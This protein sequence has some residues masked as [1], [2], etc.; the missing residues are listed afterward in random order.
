MGGIWKFLHRERANDYFI[1]R[2]CQ[3]PTR[4]KNS[5]WFTVFF[6]INTVYHFGVFFLMQSS[7]FTK[8][9][10]FG[11]ISREK[12]TTFFPVSP[13]NLF[14]CMQNYFLNL[15]QGIDLY[16]IFLIRNAAYFKTM[17]DINS[18]FCVKGV[19]ISRLDLLCFLRNKPS[20]VHR[21]GSTVHRFKRFSYSPKMFI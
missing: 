9:L 15:K 12:K 8:S 21:F 16:W 1:Y 17:K 6:S 2:S 14:L 11:S 4:K 19:K 13:K 18:K 7:K 10:N 3:I 5:Q 20:K